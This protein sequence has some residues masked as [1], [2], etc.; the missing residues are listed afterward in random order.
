MIE[1]YFLWSNNKEITNLWSGIIHCTPITPK[2][3]NSFNISL[4]FKNKYFINSLDKCLC[5]FTLS[6]YITDYL[7]KEFI[8]IKK[9]IKVFTL[10]H[11]IEMINIKQFDVKK[12][13]NNPCKK[14]IQL[15]QQ[16]RKCTSI[17]LLN[18]INHERI[19]LTGTINIKKCHI[20]LKNEIL[21][22][23][24]NPLILNNKVKMYYTETIEEYDNLLTNNIV[25]IDLFD[26]SANNT[27]VLTQTP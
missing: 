27:V 1:R 18:N 12:Y 2:Y 25:F 14:L 26:A 8:K 4:L 11:P 24:M 20:L 21:F 9:N 15:G 23:K 19:W 6:Q 13:V 22:F 5:L 16:L 17:Y 3:L 10:K 7:N